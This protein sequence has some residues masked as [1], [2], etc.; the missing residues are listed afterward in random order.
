M[1]KIS[2][3]NDREWHDCIR[4]QYSGAVLKAMVRNNTDLKKSATGGMP[5]VVFDNRCSGYEDF[6]QVTQELIAALEEDAPHLR[7][8]GSRAVNE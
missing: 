8:V 1:I 5:I 6:L 7:V 4:E 3:L 2:D